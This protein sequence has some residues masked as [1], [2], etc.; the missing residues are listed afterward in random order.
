ME[1]GFPSD[2][3]TSKHTHRRIAMRARL[4]F[5]IVIAF[6][7]G[8]LGAVLLRGMPQ[9]AGQSTS[10]GR[11]LIG[12]PFTLTDQNGRTVTEKDFLGKYSLLVFGYTFCPDICPTELGLVTEALNKLGP[13]GD[14][15]TPVFIT[16][17]P[18]RDTV[19]NV[20]NYVA[21]FHPRFVGLTGSE[22]QIKQ[23]ASAYRVYYAKADGGDAKSDTYLM[24]H[25]TFIYLMGPK[26]EY[27]T[28]FGYGLSADDLIARLAKSMPL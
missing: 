5:I 18:K 21:S 10:T 27:V 12:G 2:R 17:D 26:G 9:P 1:A 20:K 16:I 6:A 24:D 22:E 19:E 14:A 25:S 4:V 23:A 11:A 3:A 8:A 15:I 28:H 7:I 13:K